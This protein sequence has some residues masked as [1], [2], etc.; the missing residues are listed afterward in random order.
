MINDFRN[1]DITKRTHKVF[2]VSE[3]V[4]VLNLIKKENSYTVNCNNLPVS[5]NCFV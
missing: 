3:N 4:K 2:L 5:K 1:S